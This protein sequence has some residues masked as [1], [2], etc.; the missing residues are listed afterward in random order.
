MLLT[1]DNKINKNQK[2]NFFLSAQNN[3][4]SNF[5]LTHISPSNDIIPVSSSARNLG[6]IFD[7]SMSFFDQINSVSKSCNFHIRD[8]SRIRHLLHLYTATD[9]ANSLASF[10]C[11]K[12]VAPPNCMVDLHLFNLV[13]DMLPNCFLILLRSLLLKSINSFIQCQINHLSSTISQHLF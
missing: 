3:S 12:I 5:D 2:L 13:N 11:R 10:F 1:N 6:C 4:V 7:S 8:I 9:L